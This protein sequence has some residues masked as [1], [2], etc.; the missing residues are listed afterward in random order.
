MSRRS[1]ETQ[2]PLQ[3]AAAAHSARQG[4]DQL[5]QVRAVHRRPRPAAE[6]SAD[7]RGG[8][9]EHE[10]LRGEG[11]AAMML[12]ESWS[13]FEKEF[14][15]ESTMERVRKLLPEKVKKRRKLTAEEGSDAGWEEYYDYIFPEDAANQPNLK[16]LAMAKMWKRQQ[17]VNEEVVPEI[18][19]GAEEAT[20]SSSSPS[21]H[22]PPRTKLQLL[23]RTARTE[24]QRPKQN[25]KNVRRSRRR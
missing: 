23:P 2:E 20:S 18:A 14:G 4:L 17:I 19:P 7:L 21:P 24:T 1:S 3:A 22:R 12:L 5:R 11:G 16:L 25:R 6:V 10:E 15:S 8:Q 9:Q 13:D